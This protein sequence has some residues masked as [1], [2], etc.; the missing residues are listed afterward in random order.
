MNKLFVPLPNFSEIE[1]DCSCGCGK[2][3]SP[4]LMVKVQALL[5]RVT[6]KTGRKV[7]AIVTSG[8]RCERQNTKVYGGTPTNSYHMGSKKKDL[9]SAFNGAAID[10]VIQFQ[11]EDGTWQAFD[12]EFIAHEAL[13]MGIFGGIGYKIYG[14]SHNFVHLDEGPVR[15][16]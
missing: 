1:A 15:Q 4:T 5:F 16:F 9:G 13:N 11:E 7:R 6:Q 12:K 3:T 8:A 2:K 14:Y 10:V